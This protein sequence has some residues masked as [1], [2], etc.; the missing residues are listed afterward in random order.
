ME[1][2]RHINISKVPSGHWVTLD[3][4]G[5]PICSGVVLEAVI[6]RTKERGYP[7]PLVHK[8]EPSVIDYDLKAW[9]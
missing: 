8:V 9:G 5:E 3:D 1:Y 2:S 6:A 4:I 7:T